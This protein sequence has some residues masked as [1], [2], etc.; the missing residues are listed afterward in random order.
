MFHVTS[1]LVGVLF[2][3]CLPHLVAGLQGI[4]FPTPFARPRGKGKSPPI[5]NF[6]WGLANLLAGLML[7]GRH[8]IG[9]EA[10][11]NLFAALAGALAL[12]AYL[13]VHFE[14]VMRPV[15]G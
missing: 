13:A 14:K 8:P 4:P 15:D 2:C 7:F 6:L 10:D 12:G 1:V 3:N 9:L 11:A 5:V